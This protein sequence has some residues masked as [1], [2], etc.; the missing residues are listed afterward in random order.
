MTALLVLLSLLPEATAYEKTS[1]KAS[2]SAKHF[3]GFLPTKLDE[4]PIVSKLLDSS[5]EKN[6]GEKGSPSSSETIP[7][8]SF[9]PENP[10]K[11]FIDDEE[12]LNIWHEKIGSEMKSYF[13]KNF[14]P[15]CRVTGTRTCKLRFTL[16][17]S[18]IV[19]ISIVQSSGL[20][21]FD[22]ILLKSL[23]AINSE[24]ILSC[25]QGH[26]R[27]SEIVSYS[28]KF[29]T[30]ITKKSNRHFEFQTCERWRK[31]RSLSSEPP[32]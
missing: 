6:K 4:N 8:I 1:S 31:G 12:S 11:T 24:V 27:I 18:K 22:K 20:L 16:E 29:P 9:Q 13:A 26:Q 2:L 15:N 30:E 32:R 19:D 7:T 23:K 28:M 10:L 21:A 5:N 17:N 25:P 14:Q 3:K